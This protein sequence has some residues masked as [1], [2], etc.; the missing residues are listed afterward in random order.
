[1][2]CNATAASPSFGGTPFSVHFEPGWFRVPSDCWPY[3]NLVEEYV[4]HHTL[5][6][7]TLQDTVIILKFDLAFARST[8]YLSTRTLYSTFN[9]LSLQLCLHF[10]LHGTGRSK[11][12]FLFN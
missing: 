1:M 3:L 12:I 5:P 7:L 11:Q 8:I 9:D 4:V 6:Y 2:S 10:I